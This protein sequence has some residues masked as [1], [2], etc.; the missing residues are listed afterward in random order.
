MKSIRLLSTITYLVTL[1]STVQCIWYD[2]YYKW[3]T[4][5][6]EIPSN[7]QLN[8]SDYIQQNNIVSLIA[9]YEDRMWLVT[10]RYLP[11]VPF[12]LNTVPY[13]HKY[14]WWEPFF[15]L[16]NE[17]PKLRPFPSVEMNKI[18]DCN[19]LQ[20]AH[21]IDVDQYGRLWVV[22]NGR[23]DILTSSPQ[24]LCP[25]KLVIFDVTNGRSDLIFTYTFP[26]NVAP[27]TSTIIKDMQVACETKND[28]WMFIPDIALNRLVVYDHKNRQSWTA[29]H[30]SMEPDPA[31]STF[32]INGNRKFFS[33]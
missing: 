26:N 7:I 28:C 11:G 14:H 4:I 18:G 3:K 16:H 9:I 30:P 10:P 25:A 21:A 15:M 20:L 32:L 6:Y 27:N 23:I 13:S 29:Q 24:N 1:S 5:E 12:T 22:D 19:A 17:S 31:K 2:V 8:E 33:T